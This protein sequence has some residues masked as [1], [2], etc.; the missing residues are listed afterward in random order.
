MAR[1]LL[2]LIIAH[3][4]FVGVPAVGAVTGLPPSAPWCLPGFDGSPGRP[5]PPSAKVSS[6]VPSF[7]RLFCRA[8]RRRCA[9]LIRGPFPWLPPPP[10]HDGALAGRVGKGGAPRVRQ[11]A[12]LAAAAARPLWAAPPTPWGGAPPRHN[13]ASGGQ[14]GDVRP[15]GAEARHFPPRA[16]P[17]AAGD[18]SPH[19]HPVFSP[20]APPLALFRPPDG[21]TFPKHSLLTRFATAAACMAGLAPTAPASDAVH[22][23]GPLVPLWLSGG[24]PAAVPPTHLCIGG[25][26]RVCC[27]GASGGGVSRPG[28]PAVVDDGFARFP[29]TAHLHAVVYCSLVCG[30]G[31]VRGRC[32]RRRNGCVGSGG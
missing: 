19:R 18:G 25:S 6:T 26:D 28:E 31:V 7:S 21:H 23:V 29:S 4:R 3:A 24:E 30:R 8:R 13:A 12:L 1:A 9:G 22:R 32:R 14:A 11:H 16:A 20:P 15:E 17:P 10:P 5:S 2:A 27:G